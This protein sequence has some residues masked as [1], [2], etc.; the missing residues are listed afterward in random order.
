[1]TYLSEVSGRQFVVISSGGDDG[2]HA[3]SGDYIVAY[4]LAKSGAVYQ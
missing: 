3:T 4:A 2:T 1:M